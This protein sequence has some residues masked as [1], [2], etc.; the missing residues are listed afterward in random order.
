MEKSFILFWDNNRDTVIEKVSS[1]GS[2]AQWC[3]VSKPRASASLHFISFPFSTPHISARNCAAR[4]SVCG[5]SF[6][7]LHIIQIANGVWRDLHNQPVR[8]LNHVMQYKCG[9]HILSWSPA[10]QPKESSCALL[11]RDVNFQI[12]DLKFNFLRAQQRLLIHLQNIP[13]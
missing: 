8:S 4:S 1:S 12:L 7:C 5:W 3:S 2:R 10:L 13:P 9:V 11:T 6:G